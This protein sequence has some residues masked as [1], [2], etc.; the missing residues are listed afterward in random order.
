[1]RIAVDIEGSDASPYSLWEGVRLAAETLPSDAELAVFAHPVLCQSIEA[2]SNVKFIPCSSVIGMEDNPLHAVRRKKD[3]TLVKAMQ[4][5]ASGEVEAVVSCGNTGALYVA[6]YLFLPRFSSLERPAL[7]AI[8]PSTKKQVV[9]LDVGGNVECHEGHLAQF[10]EL[11]AAYCKAVSNIEKPEVALLNVGQET[12]K[13]SA[14]HRSAFQLLSELSDQKY[15]FKGNIEGR[16]VFHADIDV[17]VCDGFSG[18][19]LLKT[20]E[21]LALF[22]L[23]KLKAEFSSAASVKKLASISDLFNYV[24]HPGGFLCG[25]NGHVIKCHGAATPKS[26]AKGIHYAYD[27][28]SRKIA[29]K[30]ARYF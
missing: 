17:V 23:E 20:A 19:I 1:M 27:L 21:G 9:L 14:L 2:P 13:G 11:G 26:I 22:I 28:A 12:S 3:A 15:T 5:H 8:I 4:M 30:I 6:S 10:A 18:N 7:M 29:N 25:V 16:D 24:E